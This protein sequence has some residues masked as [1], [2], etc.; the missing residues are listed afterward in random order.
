[1]ADTSSTSLSVTWQAA[2][3]IVMSIMLG[4]IAFVGNNMSNNI[5][6]QSVRVAGLESQVAVF[7]AVRIKREAELLDIHS[8]LEELLLWEAT[9]KGEEL[10]QEK[11]KHRQ[12]LGLLNKK[13]KSKAVVIGTINDELEDNKVTMQ[14]NKVVLDNKSAALS[15]AIMDKNQMAKV[16]D[17]KVKEHRGI[18]SIFQ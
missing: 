17:E 10:Q 2:F 6:T 13:L 1:M 11:T 3:G 4:L 8:K 5:A 15:Q 16:L 18:L 7:N 12:D 9:T 14:H